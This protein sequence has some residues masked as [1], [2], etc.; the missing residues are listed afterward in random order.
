MA[1]YEYAIGSAADTL[2]NLEDDLGLPPPHPAPFREW[3]ATYDCG[4]GTVQGDGF[5][6]AEWRWD[7]LDK[8]HIATLRTYCTGKSATVYIKTLKANGQTYGTYSAVMIWPTMPDD[9]AFQ[10][11]RVS[12]NF[13]LK[14]T[15]LEEVS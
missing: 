2:Q 8:D 4:D 7:Y 13:V 11:G 6:S 3:A 9:A 14:F 10:M 15:H 1:D 12:T 5:P